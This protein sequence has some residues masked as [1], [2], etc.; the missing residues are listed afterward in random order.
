LYVRFHGRQ[1]E[2][3][4][5]HEHRNERYDYLYSRE[6]IRTH[7]SRLR[8]V[9]AA[10]PIRKAYTFFNNHPDAKAVV[11]AAMLRAELGLPLSEQLPDSL[12]NAYPVLKEA[13]PRP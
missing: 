7:A 3:W 8:T 12:I 2:K 4:W 10:Q 5:H 9:A 11:N 13:E 1:A 6:E